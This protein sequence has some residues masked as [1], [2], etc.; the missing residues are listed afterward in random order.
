MHP[1]VQTGAAVRIAKRGEHEIEDMDAS[2]AVGSID[3][4]AGCAARDVDVL[5]AATRR[6]GNAGA[7]A[8]TGRGTE[9]AERTAAA[10]G[11]G[12]TAGASA[13]DDHRGAIERGEY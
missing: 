7:G 12:A 10:F 2:G 1:N 13:A 8:T 5:R 3:C 9:A 11:S 4:G 6:A